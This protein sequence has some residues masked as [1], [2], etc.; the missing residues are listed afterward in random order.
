MPDNFRHFKLVTELMVS[1]E[2]IR[3]NLL[4]PVRNQGQ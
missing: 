2:Q 3:Q 1:I 4:Q